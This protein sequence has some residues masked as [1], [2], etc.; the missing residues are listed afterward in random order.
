[1]LVEVTYSSHCEGSVAKVSWRYP[2]LGTGNDG[3]Y[4]KVRPRPLAICPG[5]CERRH[6]GEPRRSAS[7][8]LPSEAADCGQSAV[9]TGRAA[10]RQSQRRG[11]TKAP[12]VVGT[13]TAGSAH[14]SVLR[15]KPR[16]E[17][18][19][20]RRMLIGQRG[21]LPSCKGSRLQAPLTLIM[22]TYAA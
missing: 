22:T 1:M 12:I 2:I 20:A 7:G 15:Q 13:T 14:V 3:V 6:G 5:E 10:L 16:T 18:R 17:V 11:L 19:S 21:Q 4:S 9:A 8:Q